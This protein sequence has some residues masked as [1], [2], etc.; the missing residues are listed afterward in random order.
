MHSHVYLLC[1][2]GYFGKTIADDWGIG[3]FL[4]SAQRTVSWISFEAR[5]NQ[6]KEECK[7]IDTE[8]PEILVIK[9]QP[10]KCACMITEY[11]TEEAPGGNEYTTIFNTFQT[12][13]VLKINDKK[14]AINIQVL[15]SYIWEE[16]RINATS[17]DNLDKIDLPGVSPKQNLSI[18]QP[19]RSSYLSDNKDEMTF[20]NLSLLLNHSLRRNTTLVRAIL[21][22]RLTVQCNLDFTR[23]PFDK[24]SCPFRL[25]S[26]DSGNLKEV[27]YEH[28][29][30]MMKLPNIDTFSAIAK[31]IGSHSTDDYIGEIGI[32][33]EM[34]RQIEPYLFEY[35]IPSIA[36][37]SIAPISFIIPVYAIPGRVSLVVTLILTQMNLF[38]RQ[39]VSNEY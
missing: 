8:Y 9:K 28:N 33:I 29:R 6:W 31:I 35:Y 1:F 21:S 26:K 30:T 5:R 37:V 23:F 15:L 20:S 24:H 11:D 32:D 25:N 22:W 39:Q 18:W 34:K 10:V 2:L 14:K 3:E 7:C 13:S 4:K 38:S 12:I 36:I 19:S 27:L 17:P 16:P